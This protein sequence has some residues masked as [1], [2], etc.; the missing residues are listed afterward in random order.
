MLIDVYA[1]VVC[2]WCYVGEKRLE[3]ALGE[4]PNLEAEVRWRPFQLR[5]EM[6]ARGLPWHEFAVEKFGD[7]AHMR[8]AFGHVAAAGA[9]DGVSFDSDRIASAP[10]TVDAHRLIL[11]ARKRGLEW[12]AADALFEAYFAGGKDLND[13]DDLAELAAGVGLDEA[14]VR[15]HLAGDERTREVWE[16]QEEAARLGIAGVP[17]YV[18]DG[19]YGLSGAQPV[20]VFLRVLDGTRAERAS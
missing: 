15:A 14:E 13:H 1:D 7:E 12:R 10:N 3:K 19:R 4:R 9:P 6:P 16:S 18:F 8:A 5:P 20:E 2:P 17:F 11:F